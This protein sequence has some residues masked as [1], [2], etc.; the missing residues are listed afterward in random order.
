[1]HVKMQ[2]WRSEGNFQDPA[3]RSW[4]QNSA[5][6]VGWISVL[7]QRGLHREILSPI[8]HTL[9]TRLCPCTISV[10]LRGSLQV[11][12]SKDLSVSTTAGLPDVCHRT[13]LFTS[14]L[15][16]RTQVPKLAR[17]PLSH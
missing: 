6:R 7:G 9:C 15:G 10:E 17:Q 12:V 8:K 4:A 13:R 14:M 5:Y 2:V 11:P 16:I 1:M 3:D